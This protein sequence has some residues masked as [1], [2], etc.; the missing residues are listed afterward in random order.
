[1]F[2]EN[3][4]PM[5]RGEVQRHLHGAISVKEREQK[6]GQYYHVIWNEPMTKPLPTQIVFEYLQAGSGSKV[7]RVVKESSSPG[8]V[9]AYFTIAGDSYAKKGRVLAWRASVKRGG[10]TLASKQSYMWR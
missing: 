9:D 8:T 1:M 2:D 3:E 6:I 5:A 10:K 4:D 7:Q